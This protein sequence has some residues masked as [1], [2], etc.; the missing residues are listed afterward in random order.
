MSIEQYSQKKS[1]N[2]F[3]EIYRL[4]RSRLP[5]LIEDYFGINMNYYTSMQIPNNLLTNP[6]RR[7]VKENNTEDLKKLIYKGLL[8]IDDPIDSYSLH[9]LI[10]DAVIM[11]REELFDF[12]LSQGAN[13]MV[14]DANGYTPLLKAAALGRNDMVKKMIEKGV[15]P[16]H[17]DPFANTATDKASM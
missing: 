4:Y 9:S 12:L 14:R 15:D 1:Q 7:M 17:K 10:H 3:F 8:E 11:N 5:Y 2:S 6:E 16:R 13:L